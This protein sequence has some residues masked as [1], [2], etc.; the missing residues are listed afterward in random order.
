MPIV[1]AIYSCKKS[2]DDMSL[3]NEATL[4][5][6]MGI[7]GDRYSL[8][9][10]TYQLFR[11]PGKQLTLISADGVEANLAAAGVPLEKICVRTLR[12]NI[13]LRGISASALNET[14]GMRLKLGDDVEL[15][16][17]RLCPPCAYNGAKN[18]IPQLMNIA[19][20]SCGVCCEI[21]HGGK[22]HVGSELQ[23]IAGS[24]DLERCDDGGKPDSFYICPK[25]RSL[26]QI[27][28]MVADMN[29]KRIELEQVD[30]DGVQRVEKAYNSVGL[31]FW[32]TIKKPRQLYQKN[33]Y[34]LE[35]TYFFIVFLVLMAVTGLIFYEHHRANLA[36]FE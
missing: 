29:K 7:K 23:I 15:F 34:T 3:L 2:G 22:V 32:K 25:D 26:A 36:Q 30:Y 8:G 10:G 17:H 16:V 1:D 9:T 19:W 12:R 6:G 21:I 20:D 35:H 28:K 18:K 24:K 13:A 14:L 27:K 11:E 5:A 4:I 31:K 33:A